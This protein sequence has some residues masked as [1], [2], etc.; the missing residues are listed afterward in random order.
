[1]EYLRAPSRIRLRRLDIENPVAGIFCSIH[2]FTE[3]SQL[4]AYDTL[5]L[6]PLKRVH[7][8]LVHHF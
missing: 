4:V 7:T 6:E 2:G 5:S 1:M 8:I 3:G